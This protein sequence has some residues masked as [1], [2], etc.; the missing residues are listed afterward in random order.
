MVLC[1]E[2]PSKGGMDLFFEDGVHLI[3]YENIEDCLKKIDL[4]LKDEYTRY[5]IG[6]GICNQIKKLHTSKKRAKEI[7]RDFI[8]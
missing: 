1:N 4:Y 7:I 5:E 6:E 2:I 8:K 3:N